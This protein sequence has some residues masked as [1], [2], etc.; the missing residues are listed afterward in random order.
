MCSI[1]V[2]CLIIIDFYCLFILS[3]AASALPPFLRWSLPWP[4]RRS[5]LLPRP[6]FCKWTR[7]R[8]NT[9]PSQ[10]FIPSKKS[11]QTGPFASRRRHSHDESREGA[12]CLDLSMSL[13]ALI[14]DVDVCFLPC[15]SVARCVPCV[16]ALSLSPSLQEPVN[17][18]SSH[19]YAF[20]VCFFSGS[21]S[22]IAKAGLGKFKRLLQVGSTFDDFL[23]S[24]VVRCHSA[25]ECDQS[26]RIT[27]VHADASW[28]H[29]ALKIVW[30]LHFGY[31]TCLFVLCV[32]VGDCVPRPVAQRMAASFRSLFASPARD[33]QA[34][35]VCYQGQ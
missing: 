12:A 9:N 18:K 25:E 24:K 8:R 16:A 10:I 4:L 11:V 21:A 5:P 6:P 22:S 34:S 7:C 23:K 26:D 1:G 17:E 3:V 14:V 32:Q 28:M 29:Y 35:C 2:L 20:R 13:C 30:S 31:L 19:P 33:L 27:H 15:C